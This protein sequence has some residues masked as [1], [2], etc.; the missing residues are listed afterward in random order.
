MLEK[1]EEEWG[2]E[3][4]EA[5]AAYLWREVGW[6]LPQMIT[7]LRVEWNTQLTRDGKLHLFR[8]F[9]LLSGESWVQPYN[10]LQPLLNKWKWK[11]CLTRKL[12]HIFWISSN[13]LLWN[14]YWRRWSDEL[15]TNY[16]I[17]LIIKKWITLHDNVWFQFQKTS[18]CA[19]LSL[20]FDVCA[21]SS[22]SSSTWER[23]EASN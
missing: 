9:Y 15:Y 3:E 14:V 7:S 2:E 18:V 4:E 13:S 23:W 17:K 6:V 8:N 11:R 12:I 22:F 21:W 20:H 16:V 5:A 19:I 1:E 10:T